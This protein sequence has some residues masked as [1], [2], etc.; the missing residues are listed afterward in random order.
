V[1]ACEAEARVSGSRVESFNCMDGRND[2]S[3]THAGI[4]SLLSCSWKIHVDCKQY[5]Q[6]YY[7]ISFSFVKDAP[8][9]PTS[10]LE[11]KH[12]A[13]TRKLMKTQPS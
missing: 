2:D 4:R 3:R 12:A 1:E 10:S 5:P 13:H 8:V 9:I 11:M 7:Y 6:L